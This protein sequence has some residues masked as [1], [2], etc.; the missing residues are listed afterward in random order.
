V[1]SGGG[2]LNSSTEGWRDEL[3]KVDDLVLYQRFLGNN[4]GN[5]NSNSNSENTNNLLSVSF[6]DLPSLSSLTSTSSNSSGP[7]IG[8]SQAQQSLPA[9]P[10]SVANQ[11]VAEVSAR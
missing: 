4:T 6:G 7:E 5:S 8:S 10:P 11:Q 2:N 3:S 1:G 9:L